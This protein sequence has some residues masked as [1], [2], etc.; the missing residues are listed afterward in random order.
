EATGYGARQAIET[1]TQRCSDAAPARRTAGIQGRD[2]TQHALGYFFLRVSAR[3]AQAN[4]ACPGWL[5]AVQVVAG[6]IGK[7]A[8]GT[9][10]VDTHFHGRT[11]ALQDGVCSQSGASLGLQAGV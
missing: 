5:L 8:D 3:N 2:L 9:D 1:R 4:V 11:Q 6:I 10:Q 7:K